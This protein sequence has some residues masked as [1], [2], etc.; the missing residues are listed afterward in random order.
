MLNKLNK[1]INTE[2]EMK[3]IAIELVELVKSRKELDNITAMI[4]KAI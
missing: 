3:N 1:N 2:K 4:I